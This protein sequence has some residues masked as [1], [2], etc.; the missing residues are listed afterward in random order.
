MDP[1]IIIL[2]GTAVVLFCII[3]LKLN[4]AVSLLLA[5]LVTALLTTPDL[6]VAYAQNAGKS[7]AEALAMAHL[8]V[9][10]FQGDGSKKGRLLCDLGHLP[11][12]STPVL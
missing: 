1:I 12:L 3:R 6:I 7:E 10:N 8:S 2:I 9:G 11:K 5:A 4:A